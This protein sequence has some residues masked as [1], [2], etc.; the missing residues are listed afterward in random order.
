M[1]PELL[2]ELA[3]PAGQA[4]LDRAAGLA[5]DDPLAA[6]SGLRGRG[7][8]P[9]LAAAA[10][11]QAAL[12]ARAAGKFGA[13]AARMFFTRAGLEQATRGPVAARRATRLTTAGVREI[14]DLG[15]GIGA[16]SLAFARAGIRVRGVDADPLT[17]AVASLNARALGLESLIEVRC[18]DAQDADLSTVDGV[19][20]DPARRRGDARVFDPRS[21]TPPWDFVAGL[22]DRVPHTVLKLAPGI[23]HAR[24]PPGTEAEWVSV[25]G[26]VVE[27]AFWCGPLAAVPRRATLLPSGASLVG[28]GTARAPV[29]PVRRY[30]YEPDGAVIRAHLVAEFASTVDGVL[31]DPEIAYVYADSV[32]ATPYARCYAVLDVLPF[33]VKRLRATLRERGVGRLTVKKRGSAVEPDELRRAMKLTGTGAATVVLTRIAGAPSAILVERR[34][35]G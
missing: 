24:I 25:D 11:T 27:A 15:C 21:Y 17:V 19:F 8:G 1:T 29:G 13:D 16:D 30:L 28:S 18:A 10:L 9:D 23:D 33:S 5:G 6:A 22:P 4:V 7:V 26:E 20:C 34:D 32:V 3:S 12:R 14:A 31:A 2:A 35:G